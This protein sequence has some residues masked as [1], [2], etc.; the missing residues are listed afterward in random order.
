MSKLTIEDIKWAAVR[1]EGYVHQTEVISS[2]QLNHWLGHKI[3]FKTE[4]QQKVGAFKA[5]GAINTLAWL[6]VKQQ[7]PCHVVAYSSGNHAQA[8]A[9]AAQQFK[10]KATILM[11]KEVSTIKVQATAAYGAEV[12]LCENR[13]EAEA[14]AAQLAELGAYLIP[15]YDHDQV[16]CGQGTAVLEA[17]QQQPHND[18]VFVP[19]G[20][21]GLLSGAV[22]A[23]QESEHDI[24]VFGAE[25]QAADDAIQSI[26]TGS[27]VKLD[28]S[29]DTI[30]DGVRTLAISERTFEYIKQADGIM[31][32]SEE[33]I[34]Y[35]TQ[36]LTHLLKQT[37]EPT[38]ALGMAAACQWLSTQETP[39]QVMIILSGG[40]IDHNSRQKVWSQDYLSQAVPSLNGCDS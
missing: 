28:Q 15:P 36:W 33:Q 14:K 38:S 1:I 9:W 26:E 27:I 37:I 34:M 16:I 30:A 32:V 8:V 21:G 18:A 29:P 13:Q 6:A 20:G 35:W 17:I 23:V 31:R 10:I 2:S 19:C 4:N 11:P 5:R 25:P 7:L 39:K 24:K 12:I 40:N 22:L 3:Y